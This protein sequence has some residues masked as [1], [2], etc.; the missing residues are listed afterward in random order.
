MN[1]RRPDPTLFARF[2][3][4]LFTSD[5][6][7]LRHLLVEVTTPRLDEAARGARSREPLH[8]ALVIDVSGSM[9][10]DRLASAV[11]AAEQIVDGLGEGDRLSLVSFSSDVTTHTSALP[12]SSGGRESAR[13]ILRSLRVR[14]T[15]DLAGGWLAGARLLAE[16]MQSAPRDRSHV[17]VLSDGCANRG[18]VQPEALARHA[19]EL[20][21]RGIS[22]SAIGIGEGWSQRQLEAIAEHGGGRLHHAE[23][24]DEMAAVLLGELHDTLDVALEDLIIEI[25]LP[26]G[27]DDTEVSAAGAVLREGTRIRCCSGPVLSGLR[28]EVVL[29]VLMPSLPVGT[30]L[31]FTVRVRGARG[32][33]RAPWEAQATA[34]LTA[35]T[36]AAVR[37]ARTDEHV[38]E[39][40]ARAW[41]AVSIR[42][43]VAW[44]RKRLHTDAHNY[45]IAQL[46]P[47]EQLCEGRP[48]LAPLVAELWAAKRYT[49]ER[50]PESHRKRDAVRHYKHLKGEKDWRQRV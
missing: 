25:D 4:A 13:A 30:E 33:G 2:D 27:V 45:W 40:A 48:E 36:A 21:R 20:F 5:G 12:M 15:T 17:L 11:S 9:G 50:V 43:L 47:F 10:G 19:S 8:L 14:G 31:P 1:A 7:D 37:A 39:R 46:D 34:T 28:R 3:R 18:I 42:R 6:R 16:A 26:E 23:T 41:H 38:V 24:P 44:N 49:N 32:E 35:D 22:S 29:H